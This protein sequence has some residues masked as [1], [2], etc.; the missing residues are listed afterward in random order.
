MLYLL[1]KVKLVEFYLGADQ[2]WRGVVQSVAVAHY[3]EL[4]YHTAHHFSVPSKLF[5]YPN[6]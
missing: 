6:S 2:E 1:K 5:L 3:F 4:K